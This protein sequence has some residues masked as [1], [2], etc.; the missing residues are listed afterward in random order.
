M[1]EMDLDDLRSELAEFAQPEKRGGWTPREERIIAGFE[2]IQRFADE[3]GHAP[4]HGEQY[5]IFERIYAVRLD[6]LRALDECRE[7]LAPLDRQGLLAANAGAPGDGAAMDAADLLAELREGV[8]ESDV[9]ML[10]HVRSREEKRDAE[11]IATRVVCRDFASF[12]PLFEQVNRDLAAGLRQ[13][14]PFQKRQAEIRKG[15]LFIIGGQ[16]AYVAE[17]D[18]EFLTEYD[19]RDSR[20]RVIYDNGTESN[21]LSRSLQRALHRDEAG[22]RITDPSPG[23]LFADNVEEGDT[24]TGTI[25]VL[26]SHSEDPFIA[27]RR[28]VVHKIGVT[29]GDLKRRLAD[30]KNDPTFLMADVDP[31]A[32]YK[33]FNLGRVQLENLIHRVF[34]R[35]QLS[36]E[37][38]DRFGKAVVPREWF[39]VPLEAIDEAVDRIRDGSIIEYEY[40]PAEARLVKVV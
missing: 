16:I 14:K 5:D 37:I 34:A 11:E 20:L 38:R 17:A 27:E 7:L 31:V 35:A 13:A 25:Y 10:R 29:S 40:D 32:T 36:V 15:E 33:L 26:R 28:D 3:H 8:G 30:A 39:V 21:I 9:T 22:R 4:R 12:E 19:R 24:A 2:D 18:E 1:P 6:R 23:P